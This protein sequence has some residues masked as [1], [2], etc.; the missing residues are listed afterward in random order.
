MVLCLVCFN[1]VGHAWN[2]MG[3]QL[4]AQIAYDNLSDKSKAMCE[5]Y[6]RASDKTLNRRFVQAASWL[7]TLRHKDVHWFDSLHYIDIPFSSDETPLPAVQEANALWGINQAKAVLLSSRS[8]KKDKNLSLRILIHLVGDIHQPLHTVTKVS[9]RLP[10]GDLGGNLYTLANTSL[11]QNLHKYWDN[12]GGVL[13]GQS[14]LFQIQNKAIQLEQKYSCASTKNQTDP[15]KWIDESHKLALGQVYTT[16]PYKTPGKRYQLN[17]QSVT[18]KQ[19]L[20]A[21]CRLAN[22]LNL[23]ADKAPQT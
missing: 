15:R 9:K 4:V 10:Q 11:G 17:T 5:S 8:S 6:L 22:L 1:S 20:L 21:G 23:L 2:A 18:Q 16:P 13:L 12:G 14:K 7:D 3:H 19:I